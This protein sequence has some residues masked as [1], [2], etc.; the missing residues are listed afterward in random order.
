[1]LKNYFEN[2]LYIFLNLHFSTFCMIDSKENCIAVMIYNLADGKGVII[3]DSVAIPEP[4]V[5]NQ[6]FTYSDKVKLFIKF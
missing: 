3:G 4:Y 6:D 5:S 1:M 2:R